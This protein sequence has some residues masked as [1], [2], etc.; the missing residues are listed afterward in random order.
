[1]L[2]TPRVV[3]VLVGAPQHRPAEPELGPLGRAWT[4]AIFKQPVD[5]PVA[6][7]PS[8]LTGDRPA[9]LERHGGPQRALLAYSACHYQQ[10]ND[11]LGWSGLGPGAFGENLLVTGCHED[12]VC[13]G[14]LLRLGEAELRVTQ[15]RQP[16]W[17]LARRWGSIGLPK[18]MAAA[19]RT[20]W[21]LAVARPGWI[22]PGMPL[23]LCER[24]CPEWTISVA[25]AVLYD[26]N[27]HRGQAQPLFDCRFLGAAW[28]A[29]LAVR[30]RHIVARA[31]ELEPP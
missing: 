8:G 25:L 2:S 20:G 21:Y 9:D 24:P 7:L 31:P 13:I 3:A 18:R 28:K 19:R 4:T 15:P 26:P 10:W 12:S 22:E 6:I 30:H 1:M 23:K 17:K 11:E 29:K 16:G 5:G 14:D 27:S